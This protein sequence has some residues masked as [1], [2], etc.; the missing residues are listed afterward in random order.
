MGEHGDP[1]ALLSVPALVEV[2]CQ[3]HIAH[4]MFYAVE[5]PQI[6]KLADDTDH[7]IRDRCQQ[8]KI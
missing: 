4:Q 1:R 5:A 8:Y 3:T 7:R 2:R 6:A